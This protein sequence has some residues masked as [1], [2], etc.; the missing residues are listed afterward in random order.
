MK[1]IN[2]VKMKTGEKGMIVQ[3]DGGS[4]FEKRLAAMGVTM[5]K[6]ITKLSAFVM[7]GPVAIKSGR[8]VV[9]LG[10]GMA[11]KVWIEL[12]EK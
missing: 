9:A 6:P 10:H 7:R 12:I 11:S 8:T 5:E 1:R 3:I 4:G 2:L